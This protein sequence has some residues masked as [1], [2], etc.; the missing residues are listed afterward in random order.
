MLLT[1]WFLTCRH[2]WYH[3]LLIPIGMYAFQAIST[4]NAD[5]RYLDV[6]EIW[7]II[8]IMAV[9]IPFVYLIRAKILDKMKRSE[10]LEKYE[11]ELFEEKNV[12]Q[13]IRDLFH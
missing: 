11:R 9:I 3:V 4:V 1:I 8:P 7:Y 13:Q 10:N 5:L 6:L 12:F 2:W